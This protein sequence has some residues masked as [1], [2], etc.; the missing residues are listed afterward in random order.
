MKFKLIIFLLFLC[1]C[2]QNINKAKI[3]QPFT[4][5]GFAYIYSEEDYNNKLI[6]RKL[7]NELLQIAHSN[8]R[9]G[10]LIKISNP[11]T[12]NSIILKNNKRF[13]YSNF[14][15]I[16][17]TEPVAKALQLDP[18][19]PFVEI[20]ELKKNKSFIAKKTKIYNEEKKVHSN[21]PVETVK[22]DN[23]SINKSK[24]KITKDEYFIVIGEFY[25]RN[26]AV[27]L[28]KRITTELPSFNSKKMYIKS[29]NLNKINL[30]SGPYNSIN[31]MKKDYIQLEKFGFEELDISINE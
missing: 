20:I 18:D 30:L 15:K 14:Y 22:I 9:I 3:K 6:K 24:K 21:A 4:S 27:F 26:S 29:S 5:K 7:N 11:K 10:S 2:T 19:K 1:S 8:L 31:V 23:I 28:K 17:I 16:L 25:S 13:S 12:D